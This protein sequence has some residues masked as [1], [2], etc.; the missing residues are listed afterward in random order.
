MASSFNGVAMTVLADGVPR[1][2]AGDINVRH[3]P[4][5]DIS[6]VDVGGQT[7]R[8]LD[9]SVLFT[10]GAA[11]LAFEAQV[12]VSGSLVIFDGTYN[13]LLSS[14]QRVSRGVNTN[15]PTVLNL[16]FYLLS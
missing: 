10:S 16:E 3:M 15:G 11:A 5:S 1:K 14:I 13:A 9:L 7:L 2:Y 6:Y 12:G 8:V 4:G